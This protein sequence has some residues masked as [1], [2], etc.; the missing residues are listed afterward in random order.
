MPLFTLD[1]IKDA[2]KL[3][4]SQMPPTPQY[5]WPIIS[6]QIGAQVWVKH[7]NHT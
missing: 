4:Y 6:A 3:V 2:A 7:E 5:N 1:Q